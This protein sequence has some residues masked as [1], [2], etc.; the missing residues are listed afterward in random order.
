[1]DRFICLRTLHRFS[2]SR[3]NLEL[4]F[5][6]SGKAVGAFSSSSHK[7]GISHFYNLKFPF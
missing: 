2:K 6:P 1:M 4:E 3:N 7:P 5:V